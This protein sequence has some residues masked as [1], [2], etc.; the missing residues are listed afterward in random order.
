MDP[1]YETK[2]NDIQKNQK[3]TPSWYLLFTSQSAQVGDLVLRSDVVHF[4]L[5]QSRT[6]TTQL[7]ASGFQQPCQRYRLGQRG[8]CRCEASL[9]PRVRGRV[10]GHRLLYDVVESDLHTG[11]LQTR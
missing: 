8:Q 5:C 1:V 6:R 7:G 11:L 10:L 2:K 4:H 9:G 3:A